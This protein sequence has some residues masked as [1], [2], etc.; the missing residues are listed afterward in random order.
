MIDKIAQL[1]IKSIEPFPKDN[2]FIKFEGAIQ[3]ARHKQ[4]TERRGNTINDSLMTYHKLRLKILPRHMKRKLAA[5]KR[6]ISSVYGRPPP[7]LT[8]KLAEALKEQGYRVSYSDD[9]END[10]RIIMDAVISEKPVLVIGNDSD[11]VGFSPPNSVTTIVN[12]RKGN[13]RFLHKSEVLQKLE[14]SDFQ[15]ALAF[16]VAGCDNVTAHCKNIGWAKAV[17]FVKH[18]TLTIDNIQQQHSIPLK[19]KE[20]EM[21]ELMAQQFKTVLAACGWFGNGVMDS[22]LLP[23]PQKPERSQLQEFLLDPSRQT[24]R[25]LANKFTP[26]DKRRKETRHKVP[27]EKPHVIEVSNTFSLLKFKEDTKKVIGNTYFAL[28]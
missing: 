25:Q 21:K 8:V 22:E 24:V 9:T 12:R 20:T 15:L 17:E 18:T 6:R 28:H 4:T 2:V 16:A 27:P 5:M 10:S 7:W 23:D 14:L 3:K 11:F 13:W 26:V 1:F 19:S